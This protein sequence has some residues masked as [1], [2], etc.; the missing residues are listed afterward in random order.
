MKKGED[1]VIQ[2]GGVEE[3]ILDQPKDAQA[4]LREIRTIIQST[5][6]GSI[7]TVSYFQLPGYSY[8]GYDYNGMFV[9]FSFKAPFLRLHVRPPVLKDHR[10]E[11]THYS[12]TASIISFRVDEEV[13]SVLVRKLVHASMAV[14]KNGK[15][16]EE[17][18]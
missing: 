2:A 1:K 8:P 6:P 9:W 15:A 4:K 17:A 11:L 7:E 14:M 10:T 13:P 16:S 18:H 3:Y 5:A 12:K